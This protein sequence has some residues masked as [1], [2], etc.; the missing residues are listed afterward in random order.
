M[1]A[2]DILAQ[3]HAVG[4]NLSRRGDK[5]IATPKAS[6][7]PEIVDLLRANKSELLAALS[8][9]TCNV[10][11]PDTDD[12]TPDPAAEGRRRRVL[13][14]L[15]AHPEAKYAAVSD[16]QAVPGFVLLTLAI[17]DVGTVDLLIPA[18]KWDGVLFLDLLEKH[19]GTV[20]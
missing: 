6:V 18:A 2:P 11:S 4:V 16:M 5:L 15:E 10:A 3:L 12:P 1:G 19:S 9:V 14:L 20:H 7:T 17:R 8:P 13:A